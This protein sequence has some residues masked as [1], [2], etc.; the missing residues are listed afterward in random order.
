VIFRAVVLICI[1]E[2]VLSGRY[3][4]DG[5]IAKCPRFAATQVGAQ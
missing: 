5:R 4:S 1:E 2:G 3:W